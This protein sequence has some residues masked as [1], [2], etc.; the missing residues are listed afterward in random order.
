MASNNSYNGRFDFDGILE[1]YSGDDVT[2]E[3]TE[4][5]FCCSGFSILCK[6][7]NFNL[8][9]IFIFILL[10]YYDIYVYIMVAHYMNLK[11]YFI[12]R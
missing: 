8:H 12:Y 6:Y 2:T 4:G 3:F 1:G 10:S 11:V 7:K 9:Y 5:G